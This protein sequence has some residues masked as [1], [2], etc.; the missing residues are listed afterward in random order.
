MQITYGV[1]PKTIPKGNL[2]ERFA[3]YATGNADSQLL[4]V[5]TIVD[6]ISGEVLSRL[7]RKGT[8]WKRVQ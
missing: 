7:E 8:V 6:R 2:F 1:P 4:D 5:I 3:E